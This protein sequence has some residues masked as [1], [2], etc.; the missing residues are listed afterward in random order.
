MSF[1]MS[2]IAVIAIAFV[3]TLVRGVFGFGNAIV[4]MPL[5]ALFLDVRTTTPLVS[6]LANFIAVVMLSMYWKKM[7]FKSAWQLI[8][9]ALLG[10]PIGLTFLKN[11]Y[12]EVVS[13]LLALLIISFSLYNLLKPRLI[14]LKSDKWVIPFGMLAGILGGAYNTDGPPVIIYGT[15]KRWPPDSFRATL[16]GYFFVVGLLVTGSHGM[17]GLWTPTVWRFWFA[18]LPAVVLALWLGKKLNTLIPPHQFDK[19]IHVFLIILGVVLLV[20]NLL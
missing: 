11:M 20:K 7:D 15:L 3:S 8:L 19:Y 5:L 10:I 6:L 9:S 2:L 14:Q 4:A 18:S 17:V 16:Q 12:S 13:V 1:E